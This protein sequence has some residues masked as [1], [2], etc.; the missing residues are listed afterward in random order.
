MRGKYHLLS[1]V[2]FG[3][4]AALE[5][6]NVGSLVP[7]MGIVS[8][9]ICGA[10]YCLGLILPDIDNEDSVIGRYVH[11]PVGHRGITHSAYV[12]LPFLP[13]GFLHSAFWM[14]GLGMLLHIFVDSFSRCGI[15]WFK[16][17]SGYR[18]LPSG[19]KIKK[20]FHLTLYGDGLSETI[21]AVSI[22]AVFSWLIL[23]RYLTA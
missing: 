1:G 16:P 8:K 11:L 12:L 7:D 4:Y 13:A 22:A 10:C 21:V 18:R 15:S 3:A 2:P 19:G 20:G 5:L 23:Q 9:G 14:L 17:F 6:A